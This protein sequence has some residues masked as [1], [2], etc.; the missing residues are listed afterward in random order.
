[1]ELEKKSEEIKLATA[2]ILHNSLRLMKQLGYVLEWEDEKEFKDNIYMI[3]T[4]GL[5][6]SKAEYKDTMLYYCREIV[7]DIEDDDDIINDALKHINDA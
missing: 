2:D 3:A 6:I 7:D 1:M 5:I 4:I